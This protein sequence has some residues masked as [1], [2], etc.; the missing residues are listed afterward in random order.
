MNKCAQRNIAEKLADRKIGCGNVRRDAADSIVRLY[1]VIKFVLRNTAE[2]LADRK[3]VRHDTGSRGAR[4]HIAEKNAH[5]GAACRNFPNESVQR[6]G[7]VR[8]RS[9]ALKLGGRK[10]IHLGLACSSHGEEI[11]ESVLG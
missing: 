10:S 7:T 9:A 4:R 5:L 2:K 6:I 8:N 3:I 11:Q 1:A